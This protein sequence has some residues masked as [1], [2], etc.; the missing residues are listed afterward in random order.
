MLDDA[1]IQLGAVLV[2]GVGATAYAQDTTPEER[3]Q[4]HWFGGESWHRWDYATGH[5]GGVRQNLEQAGV[6]V[7]GAYVFDWSGLWDGGTGSGTGYRSLTDFN[8]TLDLERL[9]NFTGA[10]FYID[11]V[12]QVGADFSAR[13]VGDIQVFD[14]MDAENFTSLYDFW[15]QVWLGDVARV[16]VGRMDSNEDFAYLDEGLV[17]IHST[18]GFPPTILAFPTYPTPTF[19]AALFAYPAGGWFVGAGIFDGALQDGINTGTNFNTL[20]DSDEYFVV[21]ET[22]YTWGAQQR[23]GAGRIAAGAWHASGDFG[24]FDGGTEHGTQGFYAL[25]EQKLWR[26]LNA[27]EFTDQG[28]AVM[29]SYAEA[30]DEV[31]EFQRTILF[32]TTYTG[33]FAGR[34]QDQLGALVSYGDLS[35]VVGAGFAQDE[36]A[37]ELYYKLQITPFF[38]LQPVLSY[39]VNPGGQPSI[40]NALV[41]TLRGEIL[42]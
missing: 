10:E 27:G 1:W 3:E 25:A 20:D 30:D 4:L 18:A 36:T 37:Y 8:M 12:N 11:V 2:I 38:S 21:G 13:E 22:G 5:W 42:F 19:G 41:G 35:D 31:S 16:K 33:I 34:D 24:R 9:I 14:N 26:E 39:I 15:L 28:L 6:A 17:F 23:L 32:G 40:D 7:G 29:A